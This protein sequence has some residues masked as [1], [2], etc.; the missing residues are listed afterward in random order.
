MNL[1]NSTLKSISPTATA[2]CGFAALFL[3]STLYIYLQF[4]YVSACSDFAVPNSVIILLEYAKSLLSALIF[5]GCYALFIEK[6]FS[7]TKRHAIIYTM[8]ILIV[9]IYKSAGYSVFCIVTADESATEKILHMALSLFNSLIIELFLMLACKLS[10]HLII[11]KFNTHGTTIYYEVKMF[12][13]NNPVSFS[14]FMCCTLASIV[15]LATKIQKEVALLSAYIHEFPDILLII[16]E[17]LIIIAI[18]MV[19]C[20]WLINT[21]TKKLHNI[22]LSQ[23]SNT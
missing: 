4:V 5:V 17:C 22:Y 19:G 23:N 9:E 13:F 21:F 16:V 7:G 11:K 2:V 12:S 6:M 8:L 10:I 3:I 14:S 1:K 20:H 18:Y 15:I